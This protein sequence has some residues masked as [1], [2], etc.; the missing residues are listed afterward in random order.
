MTIPGNA[1][2][3][4]ARA[5]MTPDDAL[6]GLREPPYRHNGKPAKVQTSRPEAKP[7]GRRKKEHCLCKGVDDG[8]LM[9]QCDTCKIWY[10]ERCLISLKM[11]RPARGS[12]D[13]WTCAVCTIPKPK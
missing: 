2:F 11:Q 10:H 1:T 3:K 6:Q 7:K 12:K 5:D 13:P 8:S 9:V 4:M